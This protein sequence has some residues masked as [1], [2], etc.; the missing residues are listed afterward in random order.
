MS[1]REDE[2]SLPTGS[3]FHPADRALL[4]FYG[5]H[6]DG[7]FECPPTAAGHNASISE[8]HARSRVRVL[9]AAGFLEQIERRYKITDLG[10]RYVR[11]EIDHEELESLNPN[12]NS[13]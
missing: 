8:K 12:N 11:G 5:G 7:P 9:L 2:M 3:W 13:E 1:D 6:C 4:R 10:L